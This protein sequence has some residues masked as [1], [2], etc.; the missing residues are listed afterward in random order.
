ML[1]I[2]KLQEDIFQN[3]I[4]KNFNTTDVYKEFAFTFEE[5]AEALHAYR[6]KLPDLGEELADVMIYLI[7]LAQILNV[8]LEAEVMKKIDKNLRREYRD[9]NGVITRTKDG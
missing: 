1:D 6:K 5:L 8:D 9:I 3:K 7:G 2:N 4:S